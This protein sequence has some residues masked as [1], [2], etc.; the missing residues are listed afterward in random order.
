VND[1]P[2]PERSGTP[3]LAVIPA[4]NEEQALPRVLAELRAA[5][6]TCIPLVVDD[7]STDAT[8]RTAL[9]H[10]ARVAIMPRNVG[11]GSAVQTGFLIAAR[12][13]IPFLVQVDADGQHD[14]AQ[15][16]AIL[17]PVRAGEVDVVI[18]SRF[19][20]GGTFKHAAH[21]MLLIRTFA[22]IITLVTR[23]RFTDTSSSFRAYNRRAIVFC[24]D[25]YPQGFLESIESLVLMTRAGLTVK[26]VPTV[27]R[28][29]EIGSSSLSLGRTIVYTGKVLLAIAVSLTQSAVTPR[30]DDR[31]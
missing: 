11:I 28:Q 25:H 30:E 9:E 16:D 24:A 14:P 21:R 3:F 27:I 4:L 13:G 5:H 12:E 6:P 8:A 29:R 1:A 10:G 18:G 31:R 22:R 17:A 20:D 7:G 23:Q 15:L 19:L 26:E 2:V